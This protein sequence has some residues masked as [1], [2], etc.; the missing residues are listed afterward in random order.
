LLTWGN[1]STLP[2]RYLPGRSRRRRRW[3]PAR[4]ASG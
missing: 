1:V 2:I 3:S 4:L